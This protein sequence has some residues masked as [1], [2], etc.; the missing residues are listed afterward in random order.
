MDRKGLSCHKGLLQ[1]IPQWQG[2]QR[3]FI[4]FAPRWRKLVGTAT[5]TSPHASP[6]SYRKS[7]RCRKMALARLD[8]HAGGNGMGLSLAMP[9]PRPFLP[10]CGG[11]ADCL[12][13]GRGL[14]PCS[15]DTGA[16]CTARGDL[17]E[18]ALHGL[19]RETG[20]QVEDQSPQT[21][22][23]HGRRVRVVDGSTIT[24]PDTAEPSGL[25]A[26]G[27]RVAVPA[28]MAGGVTSAEPQDRSA[29][30]SSALQNAR[31]RSQRVLHALL[32]YNLIR[33]VMATAAFHSGQ[34]PW[35]IS[36]K[37]TLQTLSQF[38]PLLLS[39]V[40]S[41]AWCVALLTAVATHNVGDRP[42]RF[43]PRLRKR[44]PNPTN[45]CANIGGTTS[46][47]SQSTYRSSSAIRY[48]Y[49]LPKPSQPHY[50]TPA[51]ILTSGFGGT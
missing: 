47:E 29:N 49:R 14:S 12:A 1:P 44:R 6:R 3:W 27:N 37:G 16:Y 17:P 50:R 8:L 24:M 23:W 39:R 20:R 15:A 41:E 13:S 42:D 25:S 21:W 22:L 4:R 28:A 46:R 26:R 31:A 10:R 40:S 19:A 18:E 7:L 2:G 38:L 30:G 33:G 34:S 51:G 32:G 11:P 9:Q 36:F 5:C 43:E 45:T 35:E 48:M